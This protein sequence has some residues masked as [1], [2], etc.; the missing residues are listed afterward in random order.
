MAREGRWRVS[1]M[2][3]FFLPF[4]TGDKAWQLKT[5]FLG[6]SV[7]HQQV[8][9]DGLAQQVTAGSGHATQ[10]FWTNRSIILSVFKLATPG[11]GE[12][13]SPET[14]RPCP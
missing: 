11:L 3:G 7:S 1:K 2:A 6:A 8:S 14:L 5:M 12:E 10:Q 13:S 9:A 4:L